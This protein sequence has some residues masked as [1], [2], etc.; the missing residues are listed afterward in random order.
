MTL[1]GD[2]LNALDEK[3]E[4][5]GV[6]HALDKLAVDLA[7]HQ[8]SLLVFER[9]VKASLRALL[10]AFNEGLNLVHLSVWHSDHSATL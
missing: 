3:V 5:F 6:V 10:Q 7:E 4:D 9:V 2:A 8:V 1:R